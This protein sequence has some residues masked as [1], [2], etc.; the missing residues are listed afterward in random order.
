MKRQITV[1]MAIGQKPAEMHDA[2]LLTQ[3]EDFSNVKIPDLG[4]DA[5]TVHNSRIKKG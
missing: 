5:I 4:I 3:G 2:W 1:N